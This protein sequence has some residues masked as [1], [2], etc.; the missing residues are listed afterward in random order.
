MTLN[1]FI[2]EKHGRIA[3][4]IKQR[5][6]SVNRQAQGAIQFYKVL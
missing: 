2:T 5:D 4:L 3:P 1:G 6:L